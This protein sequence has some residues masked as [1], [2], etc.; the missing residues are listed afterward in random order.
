MSPQLATL[1]AGV[2]GT[3]DW[4]FEIK[5][6][7]YRL[8][9]RI[10]DG[11][12]RL[13]TRGGHDWS[14]K[15][16][17]LVKEL[18]QLGVTSGFLDGEIVVLGPNGMPDFN[19]LQ[20]AFD[21]GR[22][23]E[24]IVY[25]LFD[26]PFFEGYDLRS[27]AQ[28]DRRQLLKALLEERATEHVRFSADFEA[29]AASV[30][31]S[32]CRM[33]LEGV[34]A[35]RA[36]APYSSRRTEAWLKLKCKLRQEFVVC[37]YTERSDNAAQ[38]G[39]LLLG[40]HAPDGTLVSAGSV[41]TGWSTGAARELKLKLEPLQVAKAPFAAGASKPGRWSKRAAGAERWVEPKF[42]AEVTFAE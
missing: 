41:G 7:G 28:R 18:E 39:S 34:I 22:G 17:G 42:V 9:A 37:G 10:E 20:N 21:Q 27:V 25:F 32:A 36:D 24:Q 26:V 1:A 14:S 4:I 11:R 35:K 2:P 40:V 19:A 23:A 3:G 15:M 29:D 5:F 16:P 12:A 33:N 30:L 38:I 6:D 31:T 8:M 13:I